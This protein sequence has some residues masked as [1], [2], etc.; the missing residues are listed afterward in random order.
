M[1]WPKRLPTRVRALFQKKLFEGEMDEELRFHL[2]SMIQDNTRAGMSPEEARRS[3]LVSFG[4]F[5]KVKEGCRDTRWTCIPEEIWQ[6]L[7]YAIRMMRKSPSLTSVAIIVLALGIGANTAIVSL[8]D[9]VVFRSLPVLQP[10]RLVSIDPASSFPDY[11]A[12]RLDDKVFSALAAYAGL[13]LAART[14]NSELLSGRGVSA[15]FFQVLGL[16]M[17]AGRG[18]LPEE[19]ALSGSQPVVIISYRY[20]QREFGGDPAVI[21]K[22]MRLN[23]ELLT[24]VGVAPKGFRDLGF[25]GPYQD[26]WVPIPMFGKVLHVDHLPLWRDATGS[27]GLRWLALVGRLKQGVALEQARA[28]FVVLTGNLRQTYPKSN[29]NWHPTLK[30]EDRVRWPERSGQFSYAI[31]AGAAICVLLLTCTNVAN[32]LLARGSARQRE[33]AVRFAL[34]ASRSRVIRQ[35]MAESLVLSSA[36]I[37]VSLAVCSLTLKVLPAFQGAH[38][39]PLILEL[40]V[41]HRAMMFAICIGLFT[42]ILFGLTPALV[43]SSTDVNGALKN[44]GFFRL[45]RAG[46]RWRRSL[47]VSQISLSVVLLTAAGLFVRTIV[48][49]QAMDL[50]CYGQR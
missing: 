46:S 36:A 28:R 7:R 14:I 4:G 41:D 5:D 42:N 37:V 33:I 20:W 25:A 2:E 6:D 24:I 18:F 11:S 30:S 22:P 50:G 19:D 9:T 17:A 27:R 23:G 48:R 45:A 32:L 49:F 29:V 10:N 26:V 44:E 31:L 43:A 40:S 3:A 8:I 39:T 16:T 38:R 1:L 21:G 15:N 35:L 47:V 12:I 13:P 34:G